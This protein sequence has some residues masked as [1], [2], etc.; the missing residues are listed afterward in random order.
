M[1]YSVIGLF[2]EDIR[3]EKDGRDMLI[4]IFPDNIKVSNIPGT[5]G[6]ICLYTRF[7]VSTEYEPK[8]MFIEFIAPDGTKM[9]KHDIPNDLIAQTYD[10]AR[11]KKQPLVGFVSRAQIGPLSVQTAGRFE[12]MATIDDDTILAGLLNIAVID[13]ELGT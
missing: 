5:F 6:K 9:L 8:S 13:S 4:G 2:C 12:I 1:K 11:A 3:Q 10:D 7:H